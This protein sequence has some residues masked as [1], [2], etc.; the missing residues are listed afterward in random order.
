MPPPLPS[1]SGPVISVER[2]VSLLVGILWQ[3][4]PL[5]VIHEHRI[6][7]PLAGLPRWFRRCRGLIA[8]PS[9]EL[10]SCFFLLLG[11]DDTLSS[12]PTPLVKLHT[13]QQL[14]GLLPQ[15]PI[16]GLGLLD[17]ALHTRKVLLRRRWPR[18]H[19]ILLLDELE[20]LAVVL[21]LLG[22][23]LRGSV[24]L[25]HLLLV[26]RDLLLQS[27]DRVLCALAPLEQLLH[28]PLGSLDVLLELRCPVLLGLGLAQ[29][30]LVDVLL[31]T[32][33]VFVLCCEVVGDV[34]VSVRILPHS[35]HLSDLPLPFLPPLLPPLVSLESAPFEVF[36]CLALR[37]LLPLQLVHHHGDLAF[38]LG[39]PLRLVALRPEGLFPLCNLGLHFLVQLR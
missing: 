5:V 33:F 26:C 31:S 29:H 10:C 22:R 11:R 3:R 16:P 37:R 27:G 24:I 38:Q 23:G 2:K 4:D 25:H 9:I 17:L 39:R 30:S 36:N 14:S 1:L 28:L 32:Q 35:L 6:R 15:L 13:A 20:P 12:F 7:G 34:D 21:H 19:G 18:G 8:S